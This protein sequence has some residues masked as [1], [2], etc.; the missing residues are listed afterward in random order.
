[1]LGARND[2]RWRWRIEIKSVVGLWRTIQID[3]HGIRSLVF[4]KSLQTAN[5]AEGDCILLGDQYV[6][7][8]YSG[9]AESVLVQSGDGV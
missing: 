3:V 5:I 9:V 7:W 8:S 1:M 6:G 2:W 4:L